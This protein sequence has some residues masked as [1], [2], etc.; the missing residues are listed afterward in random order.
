MCTQV[1]DH[2][3]VVQCQSQIV[4]NLW[5]DKIKQY[6]MHLM[7]MNAP[8]ET[9]WAMTNLL[10]KYRTK[11][12]STLETTNP[13]LMVVVTKQ[14]QLG[15]NCFKEGLL[16]D[17]W[18]DHVSTFLPPRQSKHKW[19]Q[20]LIHMHCDILWELWTNRCNIV[21]DKT[22]INKVHDCGD[23][24]P[25]IQQVLSNTPANLRP[26]EKLLFQTTYSALSMHT[27]RYRKLWL[28]QVEKII[29]TANERPQL[30]NYDNERKTMQNWLKGQWQTTITNRTPIRYS[31]PNS[32]Y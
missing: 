3:H 20:Q 30:L 31:R 21:H 1:E 32:Y 2:H 14:Q 16:A 8:N 17:E 7:Q 13:T 18:K 22:T 10:T 9:I 4:T 23:L 27:Y 12:I 19:I 24:E 5:S 29:K 15:P 6:D 25:R 26:H 11:D 28:Q